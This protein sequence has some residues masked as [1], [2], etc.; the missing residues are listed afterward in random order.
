MCK[1]IS[2]IILLI[3][4]LLFFVVSILNKLNLDLLI[5]NLIKKLAKRVYAFLAI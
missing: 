1:T 5:Y 4:L 2:H 3:T